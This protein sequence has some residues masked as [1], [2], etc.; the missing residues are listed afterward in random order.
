MTE[1]TRGESGEA[2]W[3]AA[4]RRERREAPVFVVGVARSGT[5]AL[6][7]TLERHPRF[8][9]REPRTAETRVFER[10]RRVLQILEPAGEPLLEFFLGDRDGAA[11]MLA[12]ARE[13]PHGGLG[14][15][16]ARSAWRR[17]RHDDLV[18][19]FFHHARRVRGVERLV[20]KTPTH[21]LHLEALRATYPRARV[22]ACVRHPVDVYSSYRK[23]LARV[24][25]RDK[26]TDR[27]QWLEADAVEFA[28]SWAECVDA[29]RGESERRP[30]GLH[31]V[32]YEDLTADPETELQAICRFVDEPFE[33]GPLLEE[34]EVRRDAHGSPRLRARIAPNE[35]RWD[36]FLDEESARV[37]EERLGSAM[38]R[39]GY[40]RYTD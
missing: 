23:R 22:I 33:A 24:R 13:V 4:S 29:I 18:R 40:E 27:L 3:R 34:V 36:E 5:T 16:L 9:P 17:A 35:K 31:W 11:R 32:R 19:V 7:N 21:A 30:D 39:L 28:R 26:Y 8:R 14:R 1:A 38:Q 15:R 20:E 6:R 37:V 10:P 12:A 25:E 2:G